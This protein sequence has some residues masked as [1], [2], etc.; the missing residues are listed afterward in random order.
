MTHDEPANA[1]SIPAHSAEA[2]MRQ[3]EARLEIYINM[4]KYYLQ[5]RQMMGPWHYLSHCSPR[6]VANRRI[7]PV[8]VSS[9][10]IR[11][12]AV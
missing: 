9:G 4:A 12:T 6:A 5:Q 2:L 1:V 8:G 3:D 10:Y 11:R 7:A